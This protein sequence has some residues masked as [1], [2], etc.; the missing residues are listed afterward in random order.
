LRL[1]ERKDSESL[2]YD[3]FNGRYRG[4]RIGRNQRAT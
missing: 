3:A 4:K 1:K 2:W